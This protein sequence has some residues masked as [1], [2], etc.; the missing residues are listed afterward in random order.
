MG[1]DMYLEKYPRLNGL[2]PNQFN[3]IDDFVSWIKSGKDCSYTE[4]CGYDEEILPSTPVLLKALE[5]VHTS[6]YKWDSEKKSPRESTYEQ[7]G[8]WRKSNAIHRWFVENV[9]DGEDDCCY[10]RP[11]TKDDLEA[12]FEVC[13]RV[14]GN[15]HLAGEL[16][17]SQSG[18]FFGNTEYDEWYFKDIKNTAD[19]CEE[20]IE[21]FDFKNYDLYYVS[22][23]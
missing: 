15:H 1:L 20:L 23:W 11:V 17:P 6:Y 5:M 7:V 14:I 22:S 8:Y 3:A 21:S 16:L 19:L 2:T 10:H 12:L 4:W 13:R 9:Q 18:F